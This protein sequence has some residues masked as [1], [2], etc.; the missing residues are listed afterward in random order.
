MSHVPGAASAFV[1]AAKTRDYLL[2]TM[3]PDGHDKAVLFASFGFRREDWQTLSAAL[4]RHPVDN[5]VLRQVTSDF[6]TKYVVR[7][8]LVSPD[9]R[10]P[11]VQ[12]VWMIDKGAAV[13]RLISAYGAEP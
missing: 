5:P 13:P 4:A 6:G 9:G 7:C 2:D 12:S 11:C 1:A 10:N 3:H 8:N